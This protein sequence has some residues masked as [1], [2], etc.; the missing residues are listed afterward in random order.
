MNLAN[1]GPFQYW[2]L[3][4]ADKERV[5]GFIQKVSNYSRIPL[6]RRQRTVN[7]FARKY[8]P[9]DIQLLGHPLSGPTTKKRCERAFTVFG[10]GKYERLASISVGHLHNLQRTPTY[11]SVRRRFKKTR[12]RPNSIGERRKGR[13]GYLHLWILCTRAT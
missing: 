13:P 8:T 4:K 9:V 3:G 12:P 5:L 6:K 11:T 1:T 7:G 2:R 10:Q